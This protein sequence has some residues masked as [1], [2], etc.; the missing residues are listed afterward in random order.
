[1]R[2]LVRRVLVFLVLIF[3]SLAFPYLPFLSF[4]FPSLLRSARL[5]CPVSTDGPNGEPLLGTTLFARVSFYEIYMGKVFDLL[6]ERQQLRVLEDS[7][8][9]NL[10]TNQP[11][12]QPTNRQ[13]QAAGQQLALSCHHATPRVTS[14]LLCVV[15][16]PALQ[17]CV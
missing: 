10:R 9:N 4:P 8:V 17:Q 13:K 1:M 12:N 7:K 11:T 16:V 6:H 3:C 5:S 2:T 14:S 15:V